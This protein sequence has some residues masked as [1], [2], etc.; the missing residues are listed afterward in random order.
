MLLAFTHGALQV[1]KLLLLGPSQGVAVP[2][3]LHCP[4]LADKAADGDDDASAVLTQASATCTVAAW[5]KGR[6]AIAAACSTP[7]VAHG[8]FHLLLPLTNFTCC[9][10]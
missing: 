10:P 5:R 2:T 6:A 3:W 4:M 9:C 8:R 1:R 7:A